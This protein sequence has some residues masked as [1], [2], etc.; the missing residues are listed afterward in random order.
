[1]GVKKI[2][3]KCVAA[4]LILSLALGPGSVVFAQD[5]DIWNDFDATAPPPPPP[6]TPSYGT[7]S[8]DAPSYDAPSYDTPSYD[9]PSYDTP[10]YSEPYD[11]APDQASV[12]ELEP[13]D[14]SAFEQGNVDA[15]AAGFIKIIRN[16]RK[17][18]SDFPDAIIEG[19]QVSIDH[20]TI[21][22]EI[23][24]TCYF[25]FRDKPSNFFYNIDRK[26]NKLNFEFVDA[27]TG[28]SPIAALEQAPIREIVIEED[29]TDVNKS[30]KGLNPEWHDVI[31]ISFEL[32]YLPVISVT[33][34]QNIISFNYKWTTNSE[35]IPQYLYKD[36]F[37][38]LFW[39][40]AG[41]LGGLGLGIL[42]Y[43]LT[44]KEPP[45]EDRVLPI[46]D[47]PSHTR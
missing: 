27:K 13:I 41:V 46:S 11:Y 7:P 21:Q 39:G 32:D 25:I 44:K 42:T 47:L 18:L 24:V 43:F 37:P 16:K 20:G 6:A 3:T 45:P 19:L 8:Y 17:E 29:Q 28:T 2:F 9:T 22:D 26:E 5:E 10:S 40:S 31:R 34:E 38:L 30:I 23:I 15:S 12:G 33:N 1:M 14:E 36:K 35:K 4:G